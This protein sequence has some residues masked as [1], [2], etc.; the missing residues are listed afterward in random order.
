MRVTSPKSVP[1]ATEA[2]GYATSNHSPK[3]TP[4]QQHRQENLR[5][6][7]EAERHLDRLLALADS[8]KDG[9]QFLLVGPNASGK[10]LF[11]QLVGMRERRKGEKPPTMVHSSMALRT[12]SH[13]HMGGLGGMLRDRP[14]DATSNATLYLVGG[15]IHNCQQYIKDGTPSSLH[16]DEPEIGSGEELQ[17]SLGP[18][19]RAKLDEFETKPV[20]TMITTHSRIIARGF[21]DWK[22]VDLGFRYKTV[23]GWLRRK[24]TPLDPEELAKRARTLFLVIVERQEQNKGKDT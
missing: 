19:I 13:A 9:D 2:T 20:V 10:S 14:D 7:E 12:G 16:L 17:A 1:C 5:D 15:A 4:R 18:W 8:I 21:R 3:M 22:L 6:W 11:R 23:D 24:I